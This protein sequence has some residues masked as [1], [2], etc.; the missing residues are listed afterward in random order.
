MALGVL[1]QVSSDA[2]AAERY[3]VTIFGSQ[4]IPK[5]PRYTHT[6]LAIVRWTDGMTP[7][8]AL[9]DMKVI[10]WMPDKLDIRTF[11]FRPEAGVNLCLEWS[12]RDA[13]RKHERISMWGPYELAPSIGPE[14]YARVC[15]QVDKLSGGNARYRCLVSET[16]PGNKLVSNCIHAVTDLVPVRNRGYI[17]KLTRFGE[18]ASEYAVHLF[19]ANR[20][21]DPKKTED[22]IVP[23]LGIDGAPV[24]A[25]QYHWHPKWGPEF[26]AN[27]S[28]RSG[29]KVGGGHTGPDW[30]TKRDECCST[31]TFSPQCAALQ[32]NR[33]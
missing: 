23:I 11:A 28:G 32:L 22:W 5:I 27:A 2:P 14:F 9:A 26:F 20:W 4:S 12:L 1:C 16:I 31:V 29:W 24:H 33:N 15:E 13:M 18:E 3:F 6:W 25:K 30:T 21:I 7:D 17:S 19:V 10:S 8:R